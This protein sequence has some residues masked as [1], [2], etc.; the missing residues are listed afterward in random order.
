MYLGNSE[1]LL[2]ELN[3]AGELLD[4]LHTLLNGVGVVG[5]GS[6]Q[7]VLVLLNLTLSPLTVSRTTILGNGS[8]D[9]EKTESS[10]G[11]LVH[12]IELVADGSDGDTGSGR[13]DGGLGDQ[14]VAGEGIDDGLSLLLGVLGGNVGDRARRGQ[15]GS[16]GSDVA[17][18]KGRPEP[19]ST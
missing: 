6:V 10:N 2:G 3:N 11:F 1:Q 15:G 14:R 19:G 7:D 16:D 4:V 12:N 9:A 13:E 17:R 5:T 8:E 18:G